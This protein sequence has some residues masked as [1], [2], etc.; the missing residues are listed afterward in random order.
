[1]WNWNWKLN[2]DVISIPK[3]QSLCDYYTQGTI[4]TF[5]WRFNESITHGKSV[6]G[7]ILCCRRK[8][9]WFTWKG[10]NC[11]NLNNHGML[12]VLGG[13]FKWKWFVQRT[14]P[15]FCKL[16]KCPKQI[17]LILKKSFKFCL[18]TGCGLLSF[19]IWVK[20]FCHPLLLLTGLHWT[21]CKQSCWKP[22]Y[23]K[24]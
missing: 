20:L 16:T 15:V 18:T 13:S 4:I 12:N 5:L 7:P 3:E 14:N 1:M 17:T 23:F 11:R 24:W 22:V 6:K 2:W 21:T 19:S 9:V 10:K 8:C